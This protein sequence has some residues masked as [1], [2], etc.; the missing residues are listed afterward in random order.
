MSESNP[1]QVNCADQLKVP[2]ELPEIA[3]L[4]AKAVIKNNPPDIIS[5]S[6]V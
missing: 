6:V 3:K 4:Y 2:P 1:V 5:F